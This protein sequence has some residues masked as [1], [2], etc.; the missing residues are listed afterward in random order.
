MYVFVCMYVCMYVFVCMYVCMYMYN[1]YMYIYI[2]YEY[3]G[4]G[5]CMMGMRV[6]LNMSTIY[7]SSYCYVSSVLIL[8]YIQRLHAYYYISSVLILLNI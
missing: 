6:L 4:K 7:V 2:I 5:I 3:E 1:I 8:L